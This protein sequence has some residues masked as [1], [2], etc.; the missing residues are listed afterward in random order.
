MAGLT[1]TTIAGSYERLLILPAGGLNGTNLVAI[2]DGD[3]DTASVLQI[4]TTSALIA[5]SGSKLLFSDNGGEY[6]SGDGTDLTITSGND[7]VLAVGATGSVY[8][9]GDGGTSNTIYGK[10]AGDALDSGGNYNVFLGE[11]AGSAMATGTN[12]IAIGYGAFDAADAG[13]DDNIAI[14][15]NALGDANHASTVRNIAIGS[16][17]MDYISGIQGANADNIFIGADAGG[18][19][20]GTA[21]SAQNVGIGN[22]TMDAAMNGALGNTVLGYGAGGAIL[23]GD[24]NTFLGRVSGATTTG[25]QFSVA[26]GNGAMGS[27]NAD[28]DA[29]GTVAIGSDALAALTS[30]IGN[31]AIG[32]ESLDAV[33]DGDF[34]TAVG[35]QAM[36]AATG[37]G[38]HNANTAVGYQA[39][40]ALTTATDSTAIGMQALSTEDVGNRSTAIGVQSLFKQNTGSAANTNN[41]GVGVFAGYHNVTGTNNTYVGQSA[42]LGASGQ[43]NSDNT[44]VGKDALLAITT[45]AGNVVIGSSAANSLT[46]GSSNVILGKN[47]GHGSADVDRCVIIG[48]SAAEGVLLADA[49]GTIAIGYSAGAALT[50]GQYSTAVGYQALTTVTTGNANTAFGY[51][52]LDLVLDGSYNTAV[53][54][55]ALTAA[56]EE[57]S[58][59]TAVGQ[60]ALLLMNLDGDGNNTAIGSEAGNIVTSGIKNTCIGTAANPGAADAI[61]QTV[62]GYHVGGVVDV[63]HSVVLGNSDVDNV[64]MA[65]DSGAIVHCHEV[66]V[67]MTSGVTDG[68]VKINA[69]STNH[70]GVSLYRDGAIK[71]Q[72]RNRGNVSDQFEIRDAGEDDGVIMA[73]GAT[74][75]SSGSDERLKCNWTSFDDALSDIDSLTKVGTFQ[76]KN[77]GE[78][79]PRNDVIHA[80]L[81]AQEVQK[82]LPSAVHEDHEGFLSMRYQELIPVL[83]KAVQELSAKVEALENA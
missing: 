16:G 30:G 22:S 70:S 73:Q 42:G 45:G 26:I 31:V 77:F 71:W 8:H 53:G 32:Y 54:Y 29:N 78:D 72:A 67:N 10:N 52:A 60:D 9:T 3:S 83:V 15:L 1:S 65:E 35:H 37:T 57:A 76:Y 38:G 20:W 14:G 13:E 24:Y 51:Q 56:P 48:D 79:N 82:F 47:A 11:E 6:I 74:A 25:I 80:G 68:H 17:A 55:R 18:G 5:G 7:I 66:Q 33:T 21:V 12:N 63:D 28:T 50:S 40:V 49:D 2:T 58:H 69:V 61:N 59:N 62:I 64:Y 81:S 19:Q 43:S 75:F 44:A 27:G 36:T 41:T 34:N 4:A 23:T 39:G 46:T